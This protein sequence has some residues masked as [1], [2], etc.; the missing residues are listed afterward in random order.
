M[1]ACGAERAS[2]ATGYLGEKE[3][4]LMRRILLVMSVAALMAAMLAVTAVPA[5]ATIHPIVESFDCANE[6]AFAHHPL[7]DPAEPPGQT[8]DATPGQGK[9]EERALQ[10]AAPQAFFGHK[11]DGQ[12]GKVGQ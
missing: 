6:Q 8:P 11:L 5:F 7:G 4:A 10:E 12:C 2:G 3:V 9:N 1:G